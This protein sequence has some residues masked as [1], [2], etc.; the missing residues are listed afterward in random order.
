MKKL[1]NTYKLFLD[2][3]RSPEDV[4]KYTKLGLYLSDWII[5]KDY[6]QF[7][8]AIYLHGL[9]NI[10]S[11]DHD[12]G[13]TDEYYIE[14]NLPSPGSEKTGY[15]CAKWLVNYC[16]DTKSVLPTYYIHSQNPVGAENID[17]L[18]K[19]YYKHNSIR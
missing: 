12:L 17:L 18:L 5:V 15:D 19:N 10:I 2:D 6:E 11:F 4:Y 1:N 9:P 13:F 14:S 16:I 3:V 7:I 8:S